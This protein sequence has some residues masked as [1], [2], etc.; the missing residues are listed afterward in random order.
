MWDTGH[1]LCFIYDEELSYHRTFHRTKY[2]LDKY[3]LKEYSKLTEVKF[4]DFISEKE[5][6]LL[7]L[8]V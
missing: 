5:R 2:E 4:D 8:E 1:W 7:L 3:G 6:N